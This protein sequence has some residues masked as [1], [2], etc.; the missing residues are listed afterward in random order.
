MIYEEDKDTDFLFKIAKNA[1]K[2]AY[3]RT[4]KIQ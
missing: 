2:D 4:E 3:F 1:S